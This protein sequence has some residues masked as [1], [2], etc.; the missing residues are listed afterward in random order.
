MT[1]KYQA[2]T[3]DLLYWATD[4]MKRPPDF[5]IAH[6]GKDYLRRWW[7]V[8]RN[9]FA[10]VYLHKILEPDDKRAFHDHPWDNTSLIIKGHYR[11]ITPNGEYIREAGEVI[12]RKATDLHRLETIDSEPIISLFITGPVIREWGFQCPQ[13]WRHW[14]EFTGLSADGKESTIGR[15]CG[16]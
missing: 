9:P 8:P 13:G 3:V 7:I 12:H 6:Y 15:G 16:D 1:D 4:I 10:N 5:V 14:K 2:S 11:E